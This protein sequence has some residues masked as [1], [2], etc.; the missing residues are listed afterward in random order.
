GAAADAERLPPA[1]RDDP[2][3]LGLGAA[4]RPDRPG[5]GSPPR[6]NHRAALEPVRSHSGGTRNGLGRAAPLPGLPVTKAPPPGPWAVEPASRKERFSGSQ[7]AR[8]S[9]SLRA[10]DTGLLGTTEGEWRSRRL[11]SSP[12]E[13]LRCAGLCSRSGVWR[14]LT[15]RDRGRA[16]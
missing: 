10:G 15:V 2:P 14:I 8:S 16:P 12:R 1:R 4:L 13:P 11:A 7:T 6:G 3:L 9:A 5:T